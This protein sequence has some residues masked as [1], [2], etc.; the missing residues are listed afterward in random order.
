MHRRR[1]SR[2]SL[3]PALVLSGLTACAPDAG[4]PPPGSIVLERVVRTDDAGCTG[5]SPLL[6][7]SQGHDFVLAAGMDG[8]VRALD[9]DTGVL[10]WSVALP[11]PDGRVANVTATP[12]LFDASHLVVAYQH[13]LPGSL[14]R[15]A[16]RIVV[17]DLEARTLDPAFPA[18]T[19]TATRPTWDGTG[20][21]AF[22]PDHSFSRAALVHVD[23]PDRTRGLVY[24]SYG[25]IR[26]IQPWHGWVF[27]LDLDAWATTGAGAAISSYLLTT[28]ED[29]CPVEG[30]TGSESMICGGGVWVPA[31]PGLR[32]TSTGYELL[33]PTGNG[34]LD[35]TR[36]QFANGV[37]RTGRGLA[38]DHG[39]TDASCTSWDPTAPVS[40]CVESCEDLFVPR[41]EPADPPLRLASGRCDGTTMF[42][43]WA[44]VDWD[45]GASTPVPVRVPGGPEIVLAAGKD[46]ALYAFDADHFGTL[47]DRLQI[48]EPCGAPGD[49]CTA[50]WAGMIVTEPVVTSVGGALLALV[51]TFEFDRTHEAGVVAVRVVWEGGALRLERAWSAPSGAEAVARFRRHPS[52]IALTVLDGEP[53]AL[54][55]DVGD[56]LG[57]GRL[58][59]LRVRDGRVLGTIEL[60]GPGQRYVR[61]LVVGDRVWVS[62]CAPGD[63]AGHLEAYDLSVAP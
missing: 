49:T 54:V 40:S 43:C 29:T 17:I 36:G 48:A 47:Y 26:D 35:P 62:S 19:P 11:V 13:V 34:M 16:H 21:V 55:Y 30:T 6:A 20:T 5:A 57:P 4:P 60:A 9:P 38:F 28:A 31:G 59:A 61:P 24:V 46:G 58:Y 2:T 52:R 27:E 18:L 3:L 15:D 33:V 32:I 8:L 7:R 37:L 23:V 53:I 63:G 51:P 41:A 25:N 14:D 10:A 50:E 44:N 12:V 39:C 56:A 45:F 42:E 22:L 1:S